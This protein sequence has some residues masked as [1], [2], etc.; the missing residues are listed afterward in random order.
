MPL[1]HR[2]NRNAFA[3]R[4]GACVLHLEH[5]RR[6]RCAA[7]DVTMKGTS[8]SLNY[9]CFACRKAFKQPSLRVADGHYVPSDIKRGA[10][11]AAE[12]A[13]ATRHNCPQ[14]QAPMVCAGRNV[15]VPPAGKT[16]EWVSLEGELRSR[17]AGFGGRRD[18]T[19]VPRRR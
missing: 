19:A 3:G 18:S 13:E 5:H 16:K 10:A 9:L 6:Q 17:T 11:E 4:R 2:G 15:V 12:Q 8:Y 14:C 1:R 7:F